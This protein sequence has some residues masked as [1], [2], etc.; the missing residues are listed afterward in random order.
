MEIKC[1]YKISNKYKKK[2][3]DIGKQKGEWNRS[4][5]QQSVNTFVCPKHGNKPIHKYSFNRHTSEKQPLAICSYH[6]DGTL[7]FARYFK[8]GKV[9]I[10]EE[11]Y[12]HY[13]NGR[14]KYRANQE[15]HTYVH[16][17]WKGEIDKSGKF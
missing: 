14:L 4:E 16:Y 12:D 17:N 15:T 1:R 5:G 3:K 6:D 8:N 9:Q 7:Y 2:N 11:W 10:Q 13:S